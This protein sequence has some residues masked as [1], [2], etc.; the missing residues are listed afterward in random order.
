LDATVFLQ[1]LTNTI[2]LGSIYSLIAIG[3]SMVFSI[4][5]ITNF[6]HGQMYMLGGYVFYFVYAQWGPTGHLGLD[7][8]LGLIIAG[9]TLAMGGVVLERIIFRPLKGEDLATMVVGL[10][11]LMFFECTALLAWGP[12]ARYVPDVMPGVVNFL[13]VT[14]PRLRLLVM[15]VALGIV[16]VL[17][18]F[19]KHAKFGQAMRAV[20]EDPVAAALQGIDSA[21]MNSIG[22]AVGSGL[23]A[24]AG[25]LLLPLTYVT[26]FV[27]GSMVLKAFTMVILGGLGSIPGAVAGAYL[28]GVSESFGYTFF[29]EV[30]A[31]FS[32]AL[33]IA[34]LIIRP[35]GLFG[36]D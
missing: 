1:T 22:F 19:L 6:A 12:T 2:V 29:G 32:F 5:R 10:G 16:V 36:R 7:F 33:I 17:F 9:M 14:V 23:A 4:M 28:V 30:A 13:G 3:L 8:L 31:L 20:A 25:G 34:V 26:P 35:R 27:G 11:L 24:V 15:G 21:R 18:L